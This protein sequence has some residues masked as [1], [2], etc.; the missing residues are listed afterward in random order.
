MILHGGYFNVGASRLSYA[1]RI[2][3]EIDARLQLGENKLV[4]AMAGT[5]AA[6][7]RVISPFLCEIPPTAPDTFTVRVVWF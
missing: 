2:G 1:G 3:N 6:P 7:A 4:I 5:A